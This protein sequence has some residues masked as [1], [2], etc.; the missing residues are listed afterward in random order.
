MKNQLYFRRLM[1]SFGALTLLAACLYGWFSWRKGAQE[2]E[3]HFAQL[4]NQLLIETR[5]MLQTEYLDRFKNVFISNA[6]SALNPTEIDPVLQ[7]L[8]RQHD[9]S[10][11][12]IHRMVKQLQTTVA[13][14]EQIENISI[15]FHK[16][17]YMLDRHSFYAV[18]SHS[19][20]HLLLSDLS[21]L[22]LERWFLHTES[23]RSDRVIE[24]KMLTYV[25]PFP[26]QSTVEQ[27]EGFMLI[28]MPIENIIQSLDKLAPQAGQK[29]VMVNL[30]DQSLIGSSQLSYQ[31]Q[32]F[33]HSITAD[34]I[35]P[36]RDEQGAY[37]RQLPLEEHPDWLLLYMQPAIELTVAKQSVIGTTLAKSLLV[38][39]F[40]M[41]F[42][43]FLA[44]QSYRPV[45]QMLD[46]IGAMNL[47]GAPVQRNEFTFVD[48]VLIRLQNTIQQLNS[49]IED[50]RLVALFHG[51]MMPSELPPSFPGKGNY[52]VVLVHL[53]TATAKDDDRWLQL[54]TKLETRLS[55]RFTTLQS[56]QIGFLFYQSAEC[57]SDMKSEI[58]HLFHE[59]KPAPFPTGKATHIVAL[60]AVVQT[61][62]DIPQ[63]FNQ[64][65]H[66]L[67]YTF[68]FDKNNP[69]QWLDYESLSQ[70]TDLPEFMYERFEQALRSGQ[71]ELM[72]E[73]LKQFEQT[74][75]TANM[76]LEA[77]ELSLMQL[78]VVLSKVI[79]DLN[80]THAGLLQMQ[81]MPYTRQDSFH[82]S[83]AYIRQCSLQIGHAVQQHRLQHP[84]SEI[85][86]QL[87]TYIDD[88]LH[89]DISLD[90]LS[91]I[92]G[93]SPQYISSLFKEVLQ[94][95]F[96]EYLTECRMQM[97]CALLCDPT[98]TVTKIA[99]KVGFQHVQYF[100]TRFK[101]RFHVT[102]NQ[103]RLALRS[104]P[105]TAK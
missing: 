96:L 54:Y 45:Q 60:G 14:Q 6:L 66:A 85:I 97:A 95:S 31:D 99:E 89:E 52:V 100:C 82:D 71:I 83:V 69:S 59:M 32:V 51:Q 16:A 67:N 36:D 102:P 28:D 90:R 37:L 62:E 30:A 47:P 23:Y 55:Y 86:G 39:L 64:A 88:H 21:H 87:K 2:A 103:Y 43:Y 78:S 8:F 93:L 63:S 65:Q 5:S 15:Y 38:L 46:K 73:F 9:F 61:V 56:K 79:L 104:N 75:Y 11:Y 57:T 26:F 80:Q 53:A 105:A 41:L 3:Q 84:K 98:L 77:V 17:G 19:P 4:G 58:K 92:A 70:R 101:K 42:S 18:S 50:T 1:I 20:K 12:Q 35:L 91:E 48:Q 76:P 27:A 49:Q 72:N 24:V 29:L 81:H 22:P 13:N 68:I 7:S 74:I 40:G 94:V 44:S 10:M 33:I 34:S 25:Y